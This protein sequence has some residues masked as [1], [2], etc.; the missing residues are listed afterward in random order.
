MLSK[1]I[2]YTGKLNNTLTLTEI[3]PIANN[4]FRSGTF[5][6]VVASGAAIFSIALFPVDTML[7]V[8]NAYQTGHRMYSYRAISYTITAWVFNSPIPGPSQRILHNL[9]ASG[10]PVRS[11]SIINEYKTIWKKTT[12]AVLLRLSNI[13]PDKKSK[14]VCKIIFKALSNKNEQELC[15]L[16]LKGFDKKFSY[17]EQISWKSRRSIHYPL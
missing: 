9:R 13:A 17:L 7:K 5:L 10:G 6:S 3:L 14:I 4:L 12:N 16:I 11:K 1:I 15:D 8:I 2:D